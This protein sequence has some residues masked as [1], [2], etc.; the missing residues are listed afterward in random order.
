MR[1]VSDNRASRILYNFLSSN[2]F[3][4]PFIAPSN[5]CEVIPTVFKEAG[6]ELVLLDINPVTLCINVDDIK[7]I[8]DYAGLLFV[9]TYG[10]ETNSEVV[11]TRIKQIEPRF[12]IIDDRCLCTPTL[13]IPGDSADMYLYS[14]GEKKQVDLGLGGFAFIKEEVNYHKC[15]L[16]NGS[17][18]NDTLWA[19]DKDLFLEKVQSSIAHRSLINAVY[20]KQLP[21]HIQLDL[22]FQNWRFNIQV[23]NKQT[24]LN[25]LFA[26]GLFASS[27]YRPIDRGYV[28]A[29]L[30]HSQIINLFN[31]Y[32]YTIEMAKKTCSI[33][34]DLL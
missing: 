25:A 2:C 12:V 26:S 1:F 30:L 31:D 17:F 28:N 22:S 11:F 24:I 4:R 3:E 18:M 14:V 5:V 8:K 16:Q 21:K 13:A 34:R 7:N 32:H 20:C 33:I 19:L 10:V 15:P 29:E 23:S 9:H 27:H 6:V